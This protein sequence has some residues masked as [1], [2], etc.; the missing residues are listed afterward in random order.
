MSSIDSL[1]DA[2]AG[3]IAAG[4]IALG[5]QLEGVP[6]ASVVDLEALIVVTSR[7]WSGTDA[8]TR[9]VALDWC[10]RYGKFVSSV[11][12]ARVAKE[13][14]SSDQVAAFAASVAASGGPRWSIAAGRRA[15]PGEVRNRVLVKDLQSDA[16]LLWRLRASF[17][18]SARADILAALLASDPRSSISDLARRTRYAKR[19]VAVS[20]E[21]LALAGLVEV[22]RIGRVDRVRLAPDAL[23]RAWAPGPRQTSPM[24]A[25]SRWRV[26]VSVVTA[27]AATQDAPA[28]VAA[29]E[30]RMSAEALRPAIIAGELPRA[31]LAVLGE[32]FALE[33]ERWAGRLA[34][35][36]AGDR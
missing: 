9:S 14:E 4:W 35:A 18:V 27:L 21:A 34:R 7:M 13:M 36:I 6:E 24:D 33:F 12:L 32:A 28:A 2:L 15:E 19:S 25:V 23:V 31:D 16:R 3:R 17:G 8:R 20:V 29:I 11:R 10:V 26:A 1:R 30:R 22:D 5:G